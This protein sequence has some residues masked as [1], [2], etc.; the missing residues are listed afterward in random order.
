[1]ASLRSFNYGYAGRSNPHVPWRWNLSRFND[2]F[3]DVMF[4]LLRPDVLLLLMY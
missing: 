4:F 3:S 2:W 1:V